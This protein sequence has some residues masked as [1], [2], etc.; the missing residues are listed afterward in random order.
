MNAYN[1]I[2]DPPSSETYTDNFSVGYSYAI[3]DNAVF[4]TPIGGSFVG[5]AV[6][7][8]TSMDGYLLSDATCFR[9]SGKTLRSTG[10]Q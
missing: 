3:T 9:F 8:N 5:S 6:Q 4:T 7:I 10:F 1:V 2:F